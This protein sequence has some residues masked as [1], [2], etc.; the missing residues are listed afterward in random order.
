MEPKLRGGGSGW[1]IHV[2]DSAIMGSRGEEIRVYAGA[3]IA[4]KIRFFF[5][6]RLIQRACEEYLVNLERISTASST[7][8][9]LT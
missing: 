8:D 6:H 9:C 3:K 4:E 7:A 2:W 1:E 5:V